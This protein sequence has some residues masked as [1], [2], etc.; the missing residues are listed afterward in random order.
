[1]KL[2][3]QRFRQIFREQHPTLYFYAAR[4]VGNE[5]AQDVVQEAFLE[6][7]KRKEEIADV[8]HI[9]AFLYRSIYTR[10][11]N[12]VKHRSVVNNYTEAAKKIEQY[13]MEYY[14]FER[15]EVTHYIE[16]IE[17]RKRIDDAIGRLPEKSREVFVLSYLHEKKK[18]EIAE[19]LG[20]SVRTVEVHL[21]RAL[22][23]LREKLKDSLYYTITFFI[24]FH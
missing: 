11:V 14:H 16:N 5:E 15:N 17:L 19:Q 9:K 13:R 7:W 10:G 24:I 6:L 8:S 21:Y 23:S 22:K 12:I 18:K 3:E 20:I 1:M 4:L 2:S